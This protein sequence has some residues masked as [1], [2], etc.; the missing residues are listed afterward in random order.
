[1]K[2]DNDGHVIAFD[3]TGGEKGDAPHVEVLM[4]L[5]PD[6]ALRAARGDQGYDS[7][8]NRA[9]CRKRGIVPVIP[10]T[11]N[12]RNKP[13]YFPKILY[14][15]RTRVEQAVGKLKRFKRI[16]LRCEKTQGISHPSSPWP[17]ASS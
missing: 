2:T 12:A 4:S 1:L 15:G 11:S 3:L 16:A 7:K 17:A 14:R 8:A 6:I 5:G 10:Y 9:L 13:K